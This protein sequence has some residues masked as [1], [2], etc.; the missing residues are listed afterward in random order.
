MKIYK[1]GHSYIDDIANSK[2]KDQFV[3]WIPGMGNSKG[4]RQ[5]QFKK[6][7][8]DAPALI[9]LLTRQS[10]HRHFNPWD[11]IVDYVAGRIYYWGDAKF[12]R[13]KNYKDFDGNKV[14]IKSFESHLSGEYIKVPPILHFTK[15]EKGK[16]TFNGLCT[17]SKLETTWYE[18]N[19]KPIRN[20]RI[21]LLILDEDEINIDWLTSRVNCEDISELDAIAPKVW[22]EYKNGRAKKIEV[23]KKE[24]KSKEQQL[25]DA[26][27]ELLILKSFCDLTATQ[28]EKAL[29]E[30]FRE[31]PNVSHNITRTRPSKDGGFDFFGEFS[32]PFPIGYRIQFLGEAKK[33]SPDNSVSPDKVSRLVSRL[34]RGQYGIFVTTSFYSKQTQEEVLEDGYPVKLY[35][36]IDLINF[37]KELRLIDNGEIKKEWMRTVLNS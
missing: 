30:I 9:V 21:E 18:D 24:V 25:P 10:S 17:F 36:G 2:S 19:G 7:K 37:L 33:Y 4:I 31:L 22:V 35:S 6:I 15:S 20:Y 23:F 16:V 27:N 28:F 13:E 26:K 3:T 34:N 1:V 14:L 12:N 11:D 32:I 8:T 5:V 29:V